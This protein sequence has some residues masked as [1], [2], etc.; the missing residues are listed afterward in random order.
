M[1]RSNQWGIPLD[2]G[3]RLPGSGRDIPTLMRRLCQHTSFSNGLGTNT[4]VEYKNTAHW[5]NDENK[6]KFDSLNYIVL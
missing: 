2:G 3:G 4:H 5:S 6:E 1:R